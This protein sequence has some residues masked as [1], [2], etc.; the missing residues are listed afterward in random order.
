M[1]APAYVLVTYDSPL[2]CP[3]CA[4][5]LGNED[6]LMTKALFPLMLIMALFVAMDS[7]N[8]ETRE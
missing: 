8:P 4:P 7:V 3:L 6:R 2:Q 1:T 5:E